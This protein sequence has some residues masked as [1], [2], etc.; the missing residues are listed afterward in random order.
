MGECVAA[1]NAKLCTRQDQSGR[2]EVGMRVF[3]RLVAVGATL[4]CAVAMGVGV[5]SAAPTAPHYKHYVALG[6][7]YTAGPLIPFIRLDPLGCVRST[8]DYPALL[9]R[10][11]RV[12]DFR[13]VSCSGATTA[14]MTA[15]QSVPFGHNPPQFHALSKDTDLVT[16]GIGG[17][18][19]DVF[20]EL[21][22]T[23]PKLRSD[24]PDGNPCQRHFTN[25]G[26]DEIKVR[27]EQTEQNVENVLA[28]I[29]ERAPA[30]KVLVIG[31]PRIVPKHG[32]CPTRLPLAK[33]D[34]TW[35]NSVEVDLD[36][37]LAKAAANDGDATYVST[38]Q[39][40]HSVC[41]TGGAAWINGQGLKLF[42]AAP[43]HP[44]ERGMRGEATI[45]YH[46]LG[47]RSWVANQGATGVRTASPGQVLKLARATPRG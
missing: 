23:C 5:A 26:V 11:L 21:I 10:K 27:I 1:L 28:G 20:G 41:A 43:Y 32:Y 30:A 7:S 17:N 16:L 31:Y 29:H 37:A 8:R 38:Y 36:D 35:L 12:R 44:F 45:V 9:A 2:T 3:R 18:D 33:G 46:R 13:D 34:Y 4:F 14:D 40:G 47:G 19:G 15:S 22:Q 25:N 6:D 39:S 24:A 42:R